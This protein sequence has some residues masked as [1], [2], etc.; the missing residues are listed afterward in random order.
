MGLRGGCGG[1]EGGGKKLSMKD[2]VDGA[3]G[4][5]EEELDRS[6]INS[7]IDPSV[8]YL[9]LGSILYIQKHPQSILVTCL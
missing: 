9:A 8:W 2:D 7:T 4:M 3:K 1:E 5:I 6:Q